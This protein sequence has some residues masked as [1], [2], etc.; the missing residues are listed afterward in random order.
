MNLGDVSAGVVPKMSLI[1]PPVA[2]GNVCTRTFIPH[3]C[4]AAIGVL[5][6]VSVATACLLPGSVA[7]GIALT[8]DGNP[9]KM[10]VEHPSGEFTVELSL[11]EKGDVRKAGLLRTARLLC[12]G[13]AYVR[14]SYD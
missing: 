7:E 6:A 9:K 14:V 13:E 1:A 2:G 5:G 12:R 10:S 3:T 11:D 4:H 8:P